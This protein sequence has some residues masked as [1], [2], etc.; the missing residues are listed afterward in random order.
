MATD[1]VQTEL[2]KIQ[3][4]ERLTPGKSGT[5]YGTLGDAA[6]LGWDVRM[7]AWSDSRGW[8]SSSAQINSGYAQLTVCEIRP[9]RSGTRFVKWHK[10]HGKRTPAGELI[11]EIGQND[12]GI[13][14]I[15]SRGNDVEVSDEGLVEVLDIRT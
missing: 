1:N 8:V 6:R 10:A 13:Y 2:S 9:P 11:D 7:L 12:D 4:I 15:D 5:Y 14:V 3:V